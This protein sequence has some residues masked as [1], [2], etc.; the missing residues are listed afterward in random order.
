MTILK[1]LIKP[2]KR[3]GNRFNLNS[4]MFK[5]KYRVKKHQRL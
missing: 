4:K 2:K 5:Q 1:W 3:Q